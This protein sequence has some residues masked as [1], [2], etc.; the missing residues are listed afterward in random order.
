MGKKKRPFYRIVAADIRAPRDGR[1][2]ELI[3][4]YDPIKEPQDIK[5]NE[6]RIL[7]WL[8]N[9]AQPTDT[10]KSLFRKKGLWLK[11]DLMRRGVEDQKIEEEFKKWEVLQLEREKSRAKEPKKAVKKEE[12]ETKEEKA[13]AK[14]EEVP[15]EQT[16]QAQQAE[17]A[18]QPQEK[19]DAM[20]G[21]DVQQEEKNDQ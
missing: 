16:D 1:F 2:I 5:L 21:S 12:K 8:R 3:G 11:W 19:D 15:K 17:P 9:G 18:E 20:E 4:T 14:K 13:E 7:Y 10:V 6:E